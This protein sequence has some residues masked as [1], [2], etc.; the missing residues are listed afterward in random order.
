MLVLDANILIRAV[1]GSRA[2]CLLRK[3]SEQADFFAPDTA[4]EE[5]REHL[6]YILD[7]RNVPVAPALAILDS[8]DRLVQTVDFESYVRF[9][10][11]PRTSRR[12]RLAGSSDRARAGLPDLDR[13]YRLL[14]LRRGDVDDGSGG[15]LPG[16]GRIVTT[17]LASLSRLTRCLPLLTNAS[18]LLSR[19]GEQYFRSRQ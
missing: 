2:L 8:L 4:F 16:R 15:V 11:L 14:W 9:E 1:L 17:G 5:A 10:P 19:K 6:P 13:G 18:M 3:Y 12:R 7:R